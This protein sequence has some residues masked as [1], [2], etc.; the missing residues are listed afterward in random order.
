MYHLRSLQSRVDSQRGGSGASQVARVIRSNSWL[1]YTTMYLVLL[2]FLPFFLFF[3]LIFVIR[4]TG[5]FASSFTFNCARLRKKLLSARRNGTAN[6]I[7]FVI[8]ATEPRNYSISVGVSFAR[9][10]RAVSIKADCRQACTPRRVERKLRNVWRR[11]GRGYRSDLRA[12][13]LS[14]IVANIFRPPLSSFELCN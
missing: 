9:S 12:Q 13:R 5:D 10:T 7:H 6:G 2:L 8:G 3:F 11:T 14:F 4:R 1:R